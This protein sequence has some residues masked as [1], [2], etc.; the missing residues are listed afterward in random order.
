MGSFPRAQVNKLQPS[1]TFF[2]IYFFV[3]CY[4]FAMQIDGGES[5]ENSSRERKRASRV[6]VQHTGS[7]PV[8]AGESALR[9]ALRVTAEGSGQRSVTAAAADCSPPT[10][11][12]ASTAGSH[13]TGHQPAVCLFVVFPAC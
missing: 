6:M 4:P 12:R 13:G 1:P 11:R 2:F 8:S 7:T 3:G 9:Q 10:K 5:R